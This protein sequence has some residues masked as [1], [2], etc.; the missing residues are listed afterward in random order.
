MSH[1]TLALTHRQVVNRLT[2]RQSWLVS[3]PETGRVVLRTG[4][5]QRSYGL[6]WWDGTDL[7]VKGCTFTETNG[8]IAATDETGRTFALYEQVLDT[9]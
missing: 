9:V 4:A 2:N 5:D 8:V 3:Y 6:Q 1:L 7:R